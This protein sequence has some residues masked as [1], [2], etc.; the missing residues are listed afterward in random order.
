MWLTSL[1]GSFER[2]FAAVIT[3][4][5]CLFLL[6]LNALLALLNSSFLTIL[7]VNIIVITCTILVGWRVYQRFIAPLKL[8]KVDINSLLKDDYNVYADLGYQSGALNHIHQDLQKLHLHFKQV[9]DTYTK[10][11]YLVYRLIS[12]FDA[13]V[14][15]VDAQGNVTYMNHAFEHWISLHDKT[16]GSRNIQDLGMVF[17]DS[18]GWSLPDS[19]AVGNW[20]LSESQFVESNQPMSLL[21]L[22]NITSEL[23]ES[24]RKAWHQMV[25]VISHEIKNSLT[26]IKSLTQSLLSKADISELNKEAL[27]VIHDRSHSLIAFVKN[28]S[29][30][31]KTITLNVSS[32]SSRSLQDSL[33]GLIDDHHFHCQVEEC[34]ITADKVLLE[35]VLINLIKNSQESISVKQDEAASSQF[36]P[37]IELI[38]YQS[39]PKEKIQIKVIDN[40]TGFHQLSDLFVPFYTTKPEGQGIGL[41]LC[42]EIIEKHHGKIDAKNNDGAG[43]CVFIELPGQQS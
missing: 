7:T 33:T 24:E 36:Q 29:E 20:R 21:V 10:D 23:R 37:K 40:G 42:R 41:Y 43:A 31:T 4:C 35:Q 32:F 9:K 26:P 28:Y 16:D 38:I 22:N 12:R 13:P 11:V 17:N 3:S 19:L 8:L 14:A 5:I 27:H 6:M 30:Q 1:L 34:Q 18:T 15:V 2:Q 25:R 39:T